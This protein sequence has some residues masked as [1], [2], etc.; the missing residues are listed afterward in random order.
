MTAERFIQ[1]YAKLLTSWGMPLTAAR[2]FAYM[3][4]QPVIPIFLVRELKVDYSEAS[5]AKGLLFYLLMVAF[6]P[7]AGRLNDR[8]GSLKVATAAF[9]VLTLFPALLFFAHGIGT[10]YLAY[11][12]FGIAM[13]GVNVIGEHFGCPCDGKRDAFLLPQAR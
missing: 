6:L 5:H 8:I 1:S 7:W 3:M 12:A 10:V 9:L 2:V 4:L 13:A 11:A